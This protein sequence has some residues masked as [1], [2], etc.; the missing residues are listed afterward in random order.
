MLIDEWKIK[1]VLFRLS[2]SNLIKILIIFKRLENVWAGE[3][4]RGPILRSGKLFR[5]L[6]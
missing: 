5:K 6:I 2:N 1:F 4:K 3:S